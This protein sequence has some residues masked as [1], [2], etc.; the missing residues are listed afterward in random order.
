[1]SF[2]DDLINNIMDRIPSGSS[3]QRIAGFT[4]VI[5]GLAV[6]ARQLSLSNSVLLEPDNVRGIPVLK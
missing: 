3:A 2:S 5:S 6:V 4:A 1:M